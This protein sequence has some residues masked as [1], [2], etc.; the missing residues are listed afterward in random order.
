MPRPRTE[1]K[2]FVI[3]AQF[4]HVSYD[5]HVNDLSDKLTFY[6]NSRQRSDCF[7]CCR[8]GTKGSRF[9]PRSLTNGIFVAKKDRVCE[10]WY[11]EIYKAT[12]TKSTHNRN[13]GEW[14]TSS[15]SIVAVHC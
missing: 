13:V 11:A 4:C 1:Y 15:K 3:I 6:Q 7:Y 8:F 9:Q 2:V 14:I 12:K 10:E 5:K